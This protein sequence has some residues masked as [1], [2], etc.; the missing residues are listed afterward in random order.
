[1]DQP[2]R[3]YIQDVTLRDGMHAIRHRYDLGMVRE[4]AEALDQA[5]VDAI[6][7]AHGDGLSGSSFNY[8]FG[9][10]TDWQ[11]I[12]TVAKA[13]RRA[14]VTTLLLPGIGT[15]HD[16]KRARDLGVESVRVA[17]HC[18][19]AD[20]SAQHIA[21]ARD[22]HTVGRLV[23]DGDVILPADG[24]TIGERR[25]VAQ[26]GQMSVAVA[27]DKGGRLLGQPVVT[28]QG[29]PVE[30]DREDFLAEAREEAAAAVGK[31]RDET[32]LK[33]KVRLAVRRVATDWTGKKPVVDVLLVRG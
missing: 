30:E 19:E 22:G 15:V 26:F 4:I 11:W 33:E 21:A 8:G 9:R 32:K 3:L 7:I 20:V 5:G 17:T 6:E 29:V 1:M 18:T 13:C 31:E 23:L 12:E 28:T 16:L 24:G 27:I 2:R 10:Q 14:R 25:R